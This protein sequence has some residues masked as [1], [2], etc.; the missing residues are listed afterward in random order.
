MAVSINLLL[1][2]L[3]VGLIVA[4]P[5]EILEDGSQL[6][7]EGSAIGLPEELETT[8]LDPNQIDLGNANG[9]D[10]A[11]DSAEMIELADL[12]DMSQV[13][14]LFCFGAFISW[15]RSKQAL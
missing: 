2:F 14:F 6:E 10:H 7:A 3:G 11:E 4:A 8:T 12:S 1:L 9:G 5:Q 13:H 15:Q